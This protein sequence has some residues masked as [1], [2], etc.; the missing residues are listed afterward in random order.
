MKAQTRHAEPITE[1]ADAARAAQAA[2][3]KEPELPENYSTLAGALRMLAQ[4]MRE[5]NPQGSD[6]LLHLACA[7]AWEA[8]R[9]SGPGLI[10][11]R[12]KQEIKILIA[13]LRTRNHLAPEASESLMDQIHSEHLGQALEESNLF[14]NA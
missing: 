10:S 14:E 7:A 12:T 4:N 3:R 11:G 6:H 5:R 13:W 9:K 2:I 1:A 8:K